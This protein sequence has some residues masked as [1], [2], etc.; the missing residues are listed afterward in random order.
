MYRHGIQR[1][2]D[3]VG[4]AGHE[5][6]ERA[7][8]EL[9]ADGAEGLSD[10]FELLIGRQI[11]AADFLAA[12]QPHQAAVDDVNRPKDAC[13]QQHPDEDRRRGQQHRRQQHGLQRFR[14]VVANQHRRKTH[15]DGAKGRVAQ[16]E[17]QGDFERAVCVDGPDLLDRAPI[18]HR[19]E[20]LPG[21]DFLAFRSGEA[22]RNGAALVVDDCRVG[23]VAA[24]GS[25]R[26]E[27]RP[28]A[29]IGAQRRLRIAAGRNRVAR[30]LIHHAAEQ[31]ADA[32][33]VFEAHAGEVRQ[34]LQAE[35]RHG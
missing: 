1:V 13:C 7:R 28:N 5:P 31:L 19:G 32:A 6:A 25:R 29:L 14:E 34:V 12:S 33:A 15:A 18:E 2:P 26:L 35:R 27:N 23:H 30:A 20:V 16:L 3:L 11:D 24:V 10:A 17:G 22:V 4:D 21:F 8:G 9:F